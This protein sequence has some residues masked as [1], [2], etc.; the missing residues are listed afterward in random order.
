MYQSLLALF[1]LAW[2]ALAGVVVG[3]RGAEVKRD[4][5]LLLLLLFVPTVLYCAAN[6]LRLLLPNRRFF[7]RW[8]GLP[9]TSYLLTVLSTVAVLYLL[10]FQTT[11]TPAGSASAVATSNMAVGQQAPDFSLTDH[12]GQ[13]VSLASLRGKY[14]LIDF[15][16]TWCG[17][18]KEVMPVVARA[19]EE[20]RGKGLEVLGISIDE[21]GQKFLSYVN[22]NG[23]AYPQLHDPDMAV[24]NAYHVQAIPSI[25]LI[26]KEGVVV[27]KNLGG[28]AIVETVRRELAR[29]G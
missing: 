5:L 9:G 17:P 23:F 19:H 4:N 25:F 15:W 14:V 26:N 3:M 20:F 22:A 16:A 1:C 29:G 18:C 6:A 21:D 10:V 13:A 28:D 27:A 11:G 12:K 7:P 24:A 2:I 8:N